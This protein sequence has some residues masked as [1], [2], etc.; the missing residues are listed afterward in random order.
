MNKRQLKKYLKSE[1]RKGILALDGKIYYS[2]DKIYDDLI[3]EI[4]PK[5]QADIFIGGTVSQ[6]YGMPLIKISER[7]HMAAIALSAGI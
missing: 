4:L 1:A 6:L 5:E 7:G 3:K 2:N